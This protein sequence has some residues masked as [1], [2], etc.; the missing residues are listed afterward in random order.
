MMINNKLANIIIL[1]LLLA[2]FSVHADTLTLDKNGN[3][4]KVVVVHHDLSSEE[5]PKTYLAHILQKPDGSI[6]K[7]TLPLTEDQWPDLEPQI[8][9]NPSTQLPSIFWS[10]F[11]GTDYEIFLSRFDGTQWLHPM[12]ITFNSI[13]D[14]EPRLVFGPSGL[15]HIMWKEETPQTPTYYYLTTEATQG[16]AQRPDVLIPPDNNFV[17]PDGTTPPGSSMPEDQD[18]FFAFYVPLDPSIIVVWGGRDD[19]SPISFQ[20]GFVLPGSCQSLSSI[21]VSRINGKLTVIFRSGNDLYY[22]YRTT[23]GW[24]PYR[25]I[26]LDDNLCEGKAELL[27]KEM[28]SGF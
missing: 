27:I 26:K 12:P 15:A 10:R 25:V 28:L 7:R 2:G 23:Q 3:L 19:P 16:F 11:D 18:F 9:I 1:I 13:D 14:R 5:N 8:D 20:E 6:E 21:K 17:L 4:H 24:V 22:T